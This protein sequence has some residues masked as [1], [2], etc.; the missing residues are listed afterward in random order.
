MSELYS[1]DHARRTD[2]RAGEGA[3]ISDAAEAIQELQNML[4]QIPRVEA[5]VEQPR[6]RQPPGHEPEEERR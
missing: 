3:L 5:E 1:K 6:H 2:T 4:R